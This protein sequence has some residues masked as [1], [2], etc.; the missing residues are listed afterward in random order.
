M[1][2]LRFY[3]VNIGHR[4]NYVEFLVFIFFIRVKFFLYF[5][6]DYVF[7]HFLPLVLQ[8][9]FSPTF[10]CLVVMNSYVLQVLHTAVTEFL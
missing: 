10:D 6:Y 7:F 1:Y 3:H 4:P 5:F 2:F 8:K 9:I